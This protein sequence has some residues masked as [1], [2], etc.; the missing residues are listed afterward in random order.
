MTNQEDWTASSA[1]PV[2]DYKVQFLVL[3][4]SPRMRELLHSPIMYGKINLLVQAKFKSNYGLALYENCVR[5]KGIP[6]TKWFRLDIFRHLMG[7]PVN[8]YVIYRDFKRRVLD[9]SIAEVN[10]HSEIFV[11]PE[12]RKQ[13]RIVTE[14]RFKLREQ[15]PD[16]HNTEP[17]MAPQSVDPQST[18]LQTLL[19]KY[20]LSRGSAIDL[21][22][23][24]AVETIQQKMALIEKSKSFKQA[25]VANLGGYLI[26]ALK[27]DY[28]PSS[29]IITSR[30]ITNTYKM[31][32]EQPRPG[33]GKLDYNVFVHQVIMQNFNKLPESGQ[34]RYKTLFA[35]YLQTQK[36]DFILERYQKFG[37]ANKFVAMAFSNYIHST[38]EDN[39]EL[40]QQIP[41]LEEYKTI[42]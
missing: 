23:N 30:A 17:E 21:L 40:C 16:G 22:N 32:S 10:A 34:T 36:Q 24:Y 11:V 13:G 20:N 3:P 4:Y 26:S 18:L 8:Q 2:L 25:A 5:Y 6:H 28:Q 35:N 14:I 27:N 1:L 31:T 33:E 9:K 29:S 12:L 37:L 15:I 7:V 41:S 19:E 39:A 42:V 38:A